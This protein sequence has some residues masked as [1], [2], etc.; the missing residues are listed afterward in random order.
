MTAPARSNATRELPE[1]VD[2]LVV[3]GG[4]S[5]A[6]V[7]LEAA[8][9]G[10]TVLL[11]E[12]Q[13]FASGT[14]SRSSKLVHGGLRYLK[15]G[16]WQ[17]T[18]ESVRERQKLLAQAPGLVEP[19]GFLMPLFDGLRPGRRTMQLGLRLYDRMAGSAVPWRSRHLDVPQ[20][21]LM[22]PRIRQSGLTGAMHY[23][24]AQTDDARLVWRVLDQAQ[25]EG[26][27]IRNYTPMLR[28]I[29]DGD[30]VTGAL[31]HDA[32][33]DRDHELRAGM[34][35]TT[36]GV[37]ADR[38]DNDSRPPTLR[39]LRGSHYLYPWHRFPLAQAV[40][41]LH[42]RDRRPVFAYPWQGATLYGTTDIDHGGADCFEPRMSTAEAEYL[43]EGLRWAFPGLRLGAEQALSS[44]AG[45][46]PVVASGKAD[47]SAESRES[48]VWSSPGL[49]NMTGGKL[50]TF[51][52]TARQLL[53]AAASQQPKLAPVAERPLFEPASGNAP[54]QLQ[55]R[56]GRTMSDYLAQREAGDEA[57]L[58]N[59]HCQ[60]G[61]LRWS[62]RHERICH[63]DDLML[64]RSRLGLLLPSG[65]EELL[66]EV[67]ALC[68]AELGWS[69]NRAVQERQRYRAIWE[70]QHAP[71]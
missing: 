36:A 18:R 2:L 30:R 42:P 71:H 13:D 65:G 50:T 10:A 4:I 62:L 20:T 63:L 7:A 59:A 34:V 5:G 19:L 33:A 22:A 1:S 58:A 53:A 44:M 70:A 40:S 47:P 14:S 11:V 24:D 39:P 35:I 41:W 54:P 49:V 66:D 45:V 61:E 9:T 67:V 37:W 60:L 6:G 27:L 48:A 52:E 38:L 31:L 8:R 16:Q 68:R 29:R 15:S 56:L 21:Q 23:V 57:P 12:A 26:A 43:D 28:L 46:R 64:R 32:I 69:E 17:L 51:R 25:A 3:G 55:G